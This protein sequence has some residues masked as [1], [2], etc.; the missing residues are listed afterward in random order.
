MIAF[1]YLYKGLCGMAHAHR[2]NAMAGHLGAALVAG[3]FFGED[4]GDLDPVVNR[5]IENELDRVLRGEESIWYNAS[6]AGITISEL[7][8]RLPEEPPREEDISAIASALSANIGKTRQSGHNVIFASLALRA[9]GDHPEYATPAMID[10]IRKLIEGFD[11]AP[12]GRGYYGKERGWI[13]GDKVP[14]PDDDEDFPPYASEAE[15][16]QV[17]MDEVIRSASMHRQ[18][19]GGLFH[20]INHATAL[21]ELSRS[22]HAGLARRG[23][24]AHRHH[25]RLWRTL[26]DLTEELGVLEKAS[27]DPRTPEYWTPA[28]TASTQ[29]SAWLT[30]RV[31]TLYGFFNLAE[32]VTDA[33]K[34]KAAEERFLY[35]MA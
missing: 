28:R 22:G 21:I 32:S 6:K 15:M 17:V 1:S 29:W 3:Y 12:P 4:H 27:H 10:G 30:H 26:P 9:L 13:M 31:K 23:L 5:A 25:V 11:G 18:G 35:L 8:A 14:L 16:A 34:R 20:I 24:P 7:F 33:A 19:F 2:A